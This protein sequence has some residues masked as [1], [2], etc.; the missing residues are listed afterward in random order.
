MRYRCKPIRP[1]VLISFAFIFLCCPSFGQQALRRP[2]PPELSLI[3]SGL[4]TRRASARTNLEKVQKDERLGQSHTFKEKFS[5]LDSFGQLHVRYDQY[6]RG[7]R[8]WDGA[9]TMHVGA[10][11]RVLSPSLALRRDLKLSIEPRVGQQ[12]AQEAA[13]ADPTLRNFNPNPARSELVLYPMFGERIGPVRSNPGEKLNA[14]DVDRYPDYHVLAWH[15]QMKGQSLQEG[16]VSRDF[17]VDA[18]SGTILKSWDSLQTEGAIGTGNSEFNGYVN[19]N[20]DSINGIYELRDTTRAGAANPSTGVAGNETRNMNAKTSGNGSVY[21]DPDNSWGNGAAYSTGTI[22]TSDTGQTPA[23][24]AAYGLQITWDYY[25]NVHNWNG[26]DNLGTAIYNKVHYSTNYSNA[27]WDD[28]CFCMTYGDGSRTGSSS[29]MYPL[30]AL[31]VVAHEISHGFTASTANL[32]YIDEPGGLNEAN[33]D[34]SAA[35]VEFYARGGGGSTIGESGG[36]WTVGEQVVVNGTPIRYM[37]KPSKDGRSPDEWYE[38]MGA[39]NVHYS[40]GPMNRAFYFLSQG[41]SGSSGSD[42]YTP[43]LPSG[44]TGVGNDKAARIWF[45][46]MSVYLTPYSFYWDARLASIRAARDLYGSGSAEVAAVKNAFAGIN[47]GAVA[48]TDDTDPT[49]NIY[50]PDKSSGTMTF[51]ASAM[52]AG[53]VA[54]VDYYLDGIWWAKR[55]AAPYTLLLDS[56]QIDNG[57]HE[58]RARARDFSGNVGQS[59]ILAFTSVNSTEQLV[60]NSGIEAGT[61]G[62]TTASTASSGVIQYESSTNN[63]HAGN[64]YMK[65]GGTGGSYTGYAYQALSLPSDA[66]SLNVSIWLKVT[67]SET[68]ATLKND[69]LAV[70][71]YN[72]AGTSY[73]V[74][75]T[76]SNLDAGGYSQRTFDLM[77]YK[78][79]SI[80]LV[81]WGTE[82]SG[83]ATTFYADDITVTATGDPPTFSTQPVSKTITVGQTTTFSVAVSG[84][85]APS[86]Q[87]QKNGVNIPGA[88]SSSYTTPAVTYPADNNAGY[89]VVATNSWASRSSDAAILTVNIRSRDLNGDGIVD[90]LDLASL[91]R[92]WNAKPTSGSWNVSCDLDGLGATGGIGDT[93]LDLWILGW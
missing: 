30:T 59:D 5:F 1:A 80:L 51:S 65:F 37:Y 50:G 24:D 58:L 81:L 87:W 74:A 7:V 39:I 38:T 9:A 3:R 42:F 73:N 14:E 91:A 70:R 56:T 82:N 29:D 8:V 16:P 27:F 90:V 49:I 44:M 13:A 41:S 32:A 68:T 77:S 11:G 55:N 72:A 83:L 19:L 40:S 66:K 62:W 2:T 46:A 52:D 18:I 54:Q 48:G 85:P 4:Q 6:Y 60:A 47:V 22:T 71:I 75:G 12:Q 25:K 36:T 78:G 61:F 20:T 92:A 67:T 34:I 93:E 86:L 79:Q 26:I 31:D 88:T 57:D 43:R 69:T 33:S 64:Y 63:A 15:V 89:T 10:D 21:T 17:I 45:R 84:N 35:M 53:G 76:L 28:G 23:V